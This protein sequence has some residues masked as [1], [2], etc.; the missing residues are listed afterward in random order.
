M[1]DPRLN[2]VHLEM[3]RRQ[4]FRRAREVLMGARGPQTL[5]AEQRNASARPPTAID[6]PISSLPGN[7]DL[8]LVDRDFVY[9]LRVGLNTVGRA[10]DNDV[11]IVD[12]YVSRRHCSIVVHANLMVELFDTASKNGTYIN[13]HRLQGPTRLHP[14][15]E[16]RMCDRQLVFM[17]RDAEDGP[18]TNTI[19]D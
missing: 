1:V 8:W 5:V 2:S 11:V 4:E 3:P 10:P 16:I 19:A 9:P 12:G 18:N 17:T 15:D 13:G 14:G 7:V 6:Q